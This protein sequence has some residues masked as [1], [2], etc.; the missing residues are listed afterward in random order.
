MK[1]DHEFEVLMLS[2][3]FR[4]DVENIRFDFNFNRVYQRKMSNCE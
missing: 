4:R 3:Q 2:H 1:F